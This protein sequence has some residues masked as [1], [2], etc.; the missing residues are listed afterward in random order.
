MQTTPQK[1]TTPKQTVTHVP[2]EAAEQIALMRWWR[3]NEAPRHSIDP[4]LLWHIPNQGTVRGHQRGAI[5]QAM[6]LVAGVPDLF[7]AI[8]MGEAHGLF[9]ELKRA[10]KSVSRLSPTQKELHALLI[11]QGFAVAICYGAEAAK[12]AITDYV[13]DGVL[14]ENNGYSTP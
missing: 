9:V 2:T 5:L 11:E 7:L 1:Q 13:T 3:E 4:R 14:F 10:S 8:P 6:G 12:K